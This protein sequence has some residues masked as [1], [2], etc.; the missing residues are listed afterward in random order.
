MG[1]LMVNIQLPDAASLQRA[2]ARAK[3]GEK[4]IE[5]TKRWNTSPRPP[6]SACF[7][8][9]CPPMPGFI[10]VSLKDWDSGRNRQPAGGA[11]NREFFMGVNEAQ[12]FAFGPR[13]FPG[14]AA[15]P[16]LP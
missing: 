15:D 8:T 1:Y 5:N 4:I 16:D 2:D 7:P 11:L 13:P 10:F 9:A 12:V 3:Q 6:G 14:W